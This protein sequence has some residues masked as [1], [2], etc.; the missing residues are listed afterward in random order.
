[1]RKI[2]SYILISSIFATLN[3]PGAQVLWDESINGPLS[4]NYLQPSIFP[5]LTLG[6]NYVRGQTEIAPNP[7]GATVYPD[8]FLISVP[9]GLQVEQ[10]VLS[11]DITDLWIWIGDAGFSEQLGFVGYFGAGWPNLPPTNGDLLPQMGIGPVQSG[12][13]GFYVQNMGPVPSTAHYELDF[14]A[15]AVPEPS[16]SMLLLV[17]LGLWR[18]T[19]RVCVL[20]H[21][22]ATPDTCPPDSAG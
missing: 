22:K 10:V 3:L 16:G 12:T 21:R 14:S 7:Y 11:S 13:Y 15:V 4:G 8:C 6:P 1:M 9:S 19:A 17:G 18:C 2:H 20:R 5:G